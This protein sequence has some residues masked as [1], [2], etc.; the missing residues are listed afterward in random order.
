MEANVAFISYSPDFVVPWP[1]LPSSHIPEWNIW[2]S[3]DPDPLVNFT[4]INT[5]TLRPLFFNA[6]HNLPSCIF[7][8][9]IFTCIC[10]IAA[11]F[12]SLMVQ[13]KL[14]SVLIFF[15]SDI[16]HF[17]RGRMTAD[18]FM[19]NCPKGKTWVC[20]NSMRCLAPGSQDAG[21]GVESQ[22][23]GC[24]S[25]LHHGLAVRTSSTSY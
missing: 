22:P 21:S 6:D 12:I 14:L 10:F 1:Y 16:R 18:Y 11:I 24:M 2:T 8:C 19:L 5:Y 23:A 7:L 20:W 9:S 13:I 3:A 4:H 15:P 25:H 17:G